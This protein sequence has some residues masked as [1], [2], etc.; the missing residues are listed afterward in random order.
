MRRF[1]F[2]GRDDVLELIPLAV[3]RKLDVAAVKIGLEAWQSLERWQRRILCEMPVDDGPEREEYRQVVVGLL[4]GRASPLP[5]ARE[6]WR[7]FASLSGRIAARGLTLT[8]ERFDSLDDEA[9]YALH[10]LSD[11]RRDPS[12]LTAAFLE[13]GLLDEAAP[14]PRA[15]VTLRARAGAPADAVV[16]EEPL[17]IRVDGDAIAVTMRTPGDDARLALGFLF[18]EGLIGAADDVGAVERCARDENVIE[19]RS[20]AGRPIDPDRVLD[21]RRWTPATS[22]C[23]VCGRRSIDD[24]VA[25]CGRVTQEVLVGAATVCDAVRR[26]RAGQR[27]FAATGGLHA[28]AAYDAAGSQLA[29]FEDIGRH[30]AVDKLCGELLLRR[31]IGHGAREPRPALLAVSGRC[32]FEI[33]Q[34]AA[35]AGIPVVASVSAASSLAIDLAS[36]AGVTLA[37]FVRAGRFN[38][39][40]HP[41][42]IERRADPWD[43]ATSS[44]I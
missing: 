44:T 32:G 26:L 15:M 35:A 24:L 7:D 8:R 37:A 16:V 13:L 33:V 2:E 40:S 1:R 34:K 21:S 22:A 27:A 20:A 3:R 5:P 25:R 12:R 4:G 28:A 42:R 43:S 39:Y 31:A 6:E 36:S 41:Q 18:A 30:N 11:P 17:E 29:I 23:G 19:V 38:V 14:A 9:R 10:K